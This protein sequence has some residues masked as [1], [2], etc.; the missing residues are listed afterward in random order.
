MKIGF[1][2]KAKNGIMLAAMRKHGMN[3]KRAAEYIG[4]SPTVFG[5]WLGMKGYPKCLTERQAAALE[6]F[7]ESSIEE[8]FPEESRCREL[9]EADK[10]FYAFVEMDPTA[11]LTANQRM[12]LIDGPGEIFRIEDLRD[13]VESA[14]SCLTEREAKVF[15]M[16]QE[17]H[18]G[19]DEAAAVFG[20]TRERVR[21]I[22]TKAL[23]KIRRRLKGP[24]KSKPKPVPRKDPYKKETP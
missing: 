13:R 21:Q 4:V 22:E 3:N 12:N 5:L 10:Q 15:H 6:A 23:N 17:Q 19:L 11:L 16:R 8:I 7:C 24:F 2:V 14:V 18:L 9:H 20:V 1:Q